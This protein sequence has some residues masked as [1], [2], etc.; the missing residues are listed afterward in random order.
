MARRKVL[1]RHKGQEARAF[2]TEWSPS[3]AVE[4]T[5]PTGKWAKG[6]LCLAFPIMYTG[7]EESHLL[8]F[9]FL[10]FFL[11]RHL[12]ALLAPIEPRRDDRE[13]VGQIKKP[14]WFKN[15]EITWNYKGY[16]NAR[17]LVRIL[18]PNHQLQ[19]NSPSPGP[20]IICLNL[21]HRKARWIFRRR[22]EM[23][24]P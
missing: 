7:Q 5:V 3:L 22:L 2:P 23:A 20:Y 12:A 1:L 9:F 13:R 8:R 6:S 18:T 15:F 16:R 24:G 17:P 4:T 21:R 14:N 10:L 11:F 19:D